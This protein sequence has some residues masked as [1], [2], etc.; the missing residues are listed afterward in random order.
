M[1]FE[2]FGEGSDSDR[3]F[4]AGKYWSGEMYVVDKDVYQTL[5]GRKGLLNSF[6]GL[7]DMSSTRM[8]ESKTR[9]VTG[10][11][12]GDGF[13]LGGQFVIDTDGKVLLD[14]RQGFYGDDESNDGL[15]EAVRGSSVAKAAVAAGGK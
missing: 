11:F 4:E 10:N 2:K 15:L 13:Q 3:S 9:G 14:H 6:Y 7:G 8:K 12:A 5:F 1:S